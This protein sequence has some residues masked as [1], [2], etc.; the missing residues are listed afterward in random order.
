[1]SSSPR[2]SVSPQLLFQGRPG[3]VR[4]GQWV[5]PVDAPLHV[6]GGSQKKQ[7]V[8]ILFGCPD[9]QGVRLNRGRAGAKGGPDSIRKHLYKMAPPMDFAWEEKIQLWDYGNLIPTEDIIETHRRCHQITREVGGLNFTV[10]VLGGGLAAS[11]SFL[12]DNVSRHFRQQTWSLFDDRPT[13]TLGSLG[14]DAGVIGAAGLALASHER[15][16]FSVDRR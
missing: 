13:I 2:T 12:P 9:D 14:D 10:I 5:K 11:G 7:E 6:Q 4:L 1:M 15:E 3:D 16:T 8:I